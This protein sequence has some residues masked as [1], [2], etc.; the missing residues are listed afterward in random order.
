MLVLILTYDNKMREGKPSH[1][2]CIVYNSTPCDG[3][4]RFLTKYIY[5]SD[6][7]GYFKFALLSG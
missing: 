2:I 1:E 4:R 3:T 7:D 6:I 5:T